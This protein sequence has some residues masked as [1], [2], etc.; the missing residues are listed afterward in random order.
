MGLFDSVALVGPNKMVPTDLPPE[1]IASDWQTK[2][3]Y[4][5]L[6]NFKIEDDRIWYVDTNDQAHLLPLTASFEIHTFISDANPDWYSYNV[7]AVEGVITSFVAGE[8]D[9]FFPFPHIPAMDADGEV[10]AKNMERSNAAMQ[11][12]YDRR[13]FSKKLINAFYS[14]KMNMRQVINLDALV[15]AFSSLLRVFK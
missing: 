12:M 8:P 6:Y 15:R 10:W 1:V 4:N 7:T 9:N 3:L 11:L 5:V 14:F 13:P 2:D